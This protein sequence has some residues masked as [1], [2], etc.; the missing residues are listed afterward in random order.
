MKQILLESSDPNIT[1]SQIILVESIEIR[2][3][4]VNIVEHE[5]LII[6]I[7]TSILQFI[8]FLSIFKSL[9]LEHPCLCR[10]KLKARVR[11]IVISRQI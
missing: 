7:L 11:S 5:Y 9:L 8:L 4:Y 3:Y 6:C 2:W 10:V 1:A